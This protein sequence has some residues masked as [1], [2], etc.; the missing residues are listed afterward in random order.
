MT[1]KQVQTHFH[2]E[3]WRAVGRRGGGLLPERAAHLPLRPQDA[4]QQP[5]PLQPAHV[6]PRRRRAGADGGQPEDGGLRD[7]HQQ[8]RLGG[9]QGCQPD[10]AHCPGVAQHHRGA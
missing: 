10:Q 6:T 9:E 8:V 5:H 2:W 4:R 7:H 3:A 1:F